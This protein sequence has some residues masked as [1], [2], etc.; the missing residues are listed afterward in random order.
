MKAIFTS[1]AYALGLSLLSSPSLAAPGITV[2]SVSTP[3]GVFSC[4]Q[5]AQVKLFSM[6]ATKV[7]DLSSITIWG[8]VGDNT[9]GVWCRG[10]EGLVIVSGNSDIKSIRDEVMSAF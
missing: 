10:S 6:G 9:V 2:H 4:K 3:Y 8:Y 1:L 7:S 5:R